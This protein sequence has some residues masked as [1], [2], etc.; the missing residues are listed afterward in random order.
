MGT[1]TSNSF[2]LL[3]EIG[4]ECVGAVRIGGATEK[5]PSEYQPITTSEWEAIVQN[6]LHR[7]SYLYKDKKQR[8]SL[9]GAQSKMGV[10]F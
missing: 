7:V 5:T 8:L 3:Q 2:R 1:D 6:N 9:A 4:K 10:L